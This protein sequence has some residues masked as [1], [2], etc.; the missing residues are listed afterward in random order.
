[1][2]LADGLPKLRAS[3]ALKDN[4]A[5]LTHYRELTTTLEDRL[6]ADA[7]IFQVPTPV[8]P[9]AG[10]AVRMDDYEHF[11]PYL[12]STTLRFSYGALRGTSLSRCLRALA[13]VPASMLKEQLEATGFSAIWIDRRG[14]FDGGESLMKGLR[15]LGLTELAHR[16]PAHVV[17]FPLDPAANPRP[18]DLTDPR[19]FEPWDVI[20]T[21]GEPEFFVYDGWY[22]LEGD[23][24]RSWRWARNVATTGIM[25]PTT[26]AVEL[27]FY[28]YSLE[29]GE[30]VLELDGRE[31]SRH[32]TTPRTRDHRVVKLYLRAGRHRVVWRF[33]GPVRRPEGGDGRMLGFAVEN[34]KL[35]LPPRPVE[36]PGKR[37]I[38]N[39]PATPASRP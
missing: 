15:E 1:V 6:G 39:R 26:Q 18:L 29:R 35:S 24:V 22:D 31:V 38:E 27:S 5:Q 13:R 32:L 12:T 16:G 20:L 17:I 37:L 10:V 33:T 19:L 2:G 30:L 21:L 9:E 25:I 4:A 23:D 7:L 36:S 11:L 28:A 34:L 14:V 3:R 8:F